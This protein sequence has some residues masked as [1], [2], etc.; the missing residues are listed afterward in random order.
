MT[1]ERR[2][3]TILFADVRGSTELG[4]SLDPED[5]RALLSRYYAI[6]REV[7][8]DYGGTIEKFI[9]DAV[10]AVFGLPVAHGDDPERALR[11]ALDLRDRVRDDPR[12]GERLPIR[13][14][15]SS[16][17][18]VARRDA[19]ADEDFLITGDPV[20]VAARLQQGA[21][22]LGDPGRR[23]DAD[24]GRRVPLRAG[25]RTRCEGQVHRRAG[26]TTARAGARP[27]AGATPMIGRDA[28]LTQLE[29]VARRA[30]T[31]R[32]PF[33][34]SIVAPAGT[35]KTRLLEALGGS[36]ARA[37]RQHDG[38]DRPVPALRPA[39]DLLAAAGRAA[40]VHRDD[41]RDAARAATGR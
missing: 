33:L 38:R 2:L 32:R 12:L 30:F 11:A 13:L 14:G 18:V 39:P 7:V 4:E 35:G 27:R 17:E 6:A 16:G 19:A 3:V 36:P 23:P 28:D 25:V 24:R 20:N 21:D 41:G 37:R 5:L 10:M 1:E 31:E 34:V 8:E 26:P 9:G 22:A 40:P 15:I 29:L